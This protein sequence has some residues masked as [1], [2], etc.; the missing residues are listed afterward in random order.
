MYGGVLA[1]AGDNG[2][3]FRDDRFAIPQDEAFPTTR[4]VALMLRDR[5]EAAIVS[6]HEGVR[7]DAA[8]A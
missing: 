7:M 1:G 2:L 8:H 5:R 3:V 4:G 6:K